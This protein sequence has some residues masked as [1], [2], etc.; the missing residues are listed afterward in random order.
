MK[1]KV[2]YFRIIGEW[3][4]KPNPTTFDHLVVSSS[5][6]DLK[7]RRKLVSKS[8][9]ESKLKKYIKECEARG[10]DVI[11]KDYVEITEKEA[12]K[13]LNQRAAGD[14]PLIIGKIVWPKPKS[15][16]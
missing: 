10:R 8:M 4:R 11:I 5:R 2:R 6:P 15:R 16:V 9:P 12:D 1:L 13:L 3:K 7:E 14:E